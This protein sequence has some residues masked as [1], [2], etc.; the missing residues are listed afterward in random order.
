MGARGRGTIS[1]VRRF[2]LALIVLVACGSSGF[3]RFT[4]RADIEGSDGRAQLRVRIA[5]SDGE[6]RRGLMGVEELA[7][8][9]GMVF[10][11]EEPRSSG[12]WMKDTLIPLSIAWYGSDG[13]NVAFAEMVPCVAEPCRVYEPGAEYVG[14]AEANAG[15]FTAHG[16]EIGDRITIAEASRG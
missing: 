15:F 14:A 1:A 2:V 3:E 6:R 7:P 5:D 9:E 12:F 11:F 13:R 10:L 4:H 8:D 16:V